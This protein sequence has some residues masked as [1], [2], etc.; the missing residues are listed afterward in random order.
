MSLDIL[1]AKRV[2][3]GWHTLVLQVQQDCEALQAAVELTGK[4]LQRVL[5]HCTACLP[6]ELNLNSET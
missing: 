2:C 6:P 1:P 5:I 3:Q 4:Y